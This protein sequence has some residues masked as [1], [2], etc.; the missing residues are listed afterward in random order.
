[1]H[2]ATLQQSDCYVIEHKNLID[3]V[4]K[5][6]SG[7]HASAPILLALSGAVIFGTIVSVAFFP[8]AIAPLVLALIILMIG[9]A[10]LTFFSIFATGEII[11]ARFDKTA[12][13]MNLLYHGPTANTV[14]T[15]PLE[16][17]A[18]IRM[19]K[20]YN[21]MGSKVVTPVIELAN[22]RSIT[23]PANTTWNDIEAVRRLIKP[24]RQEL[25]AAWARKS[26]AIKTG[27][28]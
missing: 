5:Q 8:S 6:Y 26:K 14:W 4:A 28:F 12:G 27:Y 15:V 16:Q 3:F 1:M 10:G 19:A 22:G 24:S 7:W 25:D 23:L 21:D 11:E 18:A 2:S 20:S 9:S 13:V 17:L